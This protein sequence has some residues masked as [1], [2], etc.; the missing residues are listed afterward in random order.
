MSEILFIIGV[1][2]SVVVVLY[3]ASALMD[4]F[5][6]DGVPFLEEGW[7]LATKRPA[8][9]RYEY[10][11]QSDITTQELAYVV[12]AVIHG[13]D[14]TQLPQ[15]EQIQR[16]FRPFKSWD[17]LKEPHFNFIDKPVEPGRYINPSDGTGG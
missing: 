11:P 15:W 7:P 13:K 17:E 1:V 8:V 12:A 16:H 2:I 10:T 6:R 4:Y 9:T 5:V 3:L 14:P